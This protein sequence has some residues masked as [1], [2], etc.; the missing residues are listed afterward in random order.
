GMVENL[1]LFSQIGTNTAF[2]LVMPVTTSNDVLNIQF[3][4]GTGSALGAK[5]NAIVVGAAQVLTPVAPSNLTANAPSGGDIDLSW[6]DNSANETSFQIEVSTDGNNYTTLAVV[7]AN[8]T[9][10]S[11]TGLNPSTIYYYRVRA[12]NAAGCSSAA[13]VTGQTQTQGAPPAAPS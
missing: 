4:T 8:V 11:H 6:S 1:D 5:V 13:N 10:Y 7:G 12:C 9:S 2:D 3:Q